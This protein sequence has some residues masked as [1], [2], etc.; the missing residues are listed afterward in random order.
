M[1]K[2]FIVEDH[3]MVI[4]GMRALLEN[5][6]GIEW[7]G[8]AKLPAALM[9]FLRTRQPDIILMDINLPKKSGWRKSGNYSYKT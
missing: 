7:M 4:E 8:Y 1:I 3:Q 9:D 6:A 2:V 5:E